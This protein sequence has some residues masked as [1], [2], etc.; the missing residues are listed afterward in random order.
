MVIGSKKRRPIPDIVE[1][2]VENVEELIIE[3]AEEIED[4]F[5]CD[6]DSYDN[7]KS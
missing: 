3:T 7:P 4:L 1:D 6:D 2:I 5:D